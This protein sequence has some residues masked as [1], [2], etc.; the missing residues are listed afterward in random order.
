MVSANQ[1]EVR[2]KVKEMY[3]EVAKN[4]QGEFHFDLGRKLAEKLGYSSQDLDKIPPEA[5]E[6]FAGVGYHLDLADVKEGESVLDL[7]SGSGMDSFLAALKVGTTAKVV[8]IDMTEEQLAKARR[9]SEN[10][11]NVTFQKGYIE[12]LPL[13]DKSFD[14]VISN[15]VINLCTEKEKVF[16]EIDR[17]LKQGGRMAISDIVTEKEPPEDIICNATLWASCIGGAMQLDRFKRSI[18]VGNMKIVKIRENPQYH[19]LSD[20]A[21]SATKTFGVKSVSILAKK[22]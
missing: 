13:E 17:V 18:E 10:F 6:S 2:T 14:A 21:Q 9:L 1:E 15:G 16:K 11:N 8:G 19:F 5:V 12:E 7:G 4:P 22:G 3:K 20:S